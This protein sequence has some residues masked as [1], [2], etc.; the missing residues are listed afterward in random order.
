MSLHALWDGSGQWWIRTVVGVV[1]FA[2][3]LIVVR[4]S[5]RAAEREQPV[6]EGTLGPVAP[7]P[8]PVG[9]GPR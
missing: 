8:G 7:P 5:R 6:P 4:R 1:S 2:G 3:L 9:P